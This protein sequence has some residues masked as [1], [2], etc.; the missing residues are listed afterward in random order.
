M[1]KYAYS[2]LEANK[3]LMN[4]SMYYKHFNFTHGI[5]NQTI[6]VY[7]NIPPKVKISN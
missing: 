1:N 2:N 4:V 5:R 7:K 6:F 3:W